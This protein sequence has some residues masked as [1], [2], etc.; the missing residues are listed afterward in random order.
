MLNARFARVE[1]LPRIVQIY[2][3]T[4]AC[5]TVTADTAEVSVE[6]RLAWFNRH[7]QTKRPLWVFSDSVDNVLGWLSFESFY[8]RPAYDKTVE[9]SLY[10]D[11]NNRGKGLGTEIL[12]FAVDNCRRCNVETLLAYVFDRNKQ[13]IRLFTKF[14][15]QEWGK[16][17]S[18]AEIEGT[19][20]SL[21]ILG[22]KVALNHS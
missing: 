15:F 2:N 5:K 4:I 9:V 13:S 21:V 12:A 1:D 11:Q 20:L 8:G 6:E 19:K 3:S 14:G 17:P 22:L 10:I 18:V 16:L 7:N